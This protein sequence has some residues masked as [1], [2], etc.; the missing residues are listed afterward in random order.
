MTRGLALLLVLGVRAAYAAPHQV[1]VLR[2]EGSA[3]TASR[4]SIDSHVLR[5]AKSID[6]K[7]EPGDITLAEAAAAVGCN[8]AEAACKDDVLATLGVDEVVAP[9]ATATAGGVTV[10]VRRLARGSA[11]R[12][13]QTTLPPGKAPDAK[14]NADL[15]PLFGVGLATTALVDKP[16]DKPAARLAVEAADKPPEVAATSSEKSQFE[17]LLPEDGPPADTRTAPIHES[18]VTAA[19]N[20]QVAPEGRPNRRLQKIGMGVGGTFVALGFILWSQASGK[21]AE[22]D[23]ATLNT[24]ADFRRVQELESE[25][26][27][28]AGAGNFFFLTGVLVGG[29]SGY[30]YWRKGRQATSTGQARIAPAAFPHGAGLT[31]TIGGAR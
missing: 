16:A 31:L 8:P 9:T 15:G 2:T 25:G 30:F 20:G 13:A 6:G 27:T 10:T 18:T 3:D 29:V 7:V 17:H 1:L 12:A 11:P 23:A 14:I 26:D 5:L 19:P 22:I 21:Q 24:P 4:T 28:L